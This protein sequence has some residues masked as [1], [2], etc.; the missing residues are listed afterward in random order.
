M[1]D[2]IALTS[3]NVLLFFFGGGGGGGRVEG[4]G[5]DGE[6]GGVR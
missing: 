3:I 5:E 6:E 1:A 2:P 4:E